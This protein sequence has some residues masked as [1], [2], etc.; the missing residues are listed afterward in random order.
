MNKKL[1]MIPN[2]LS[3]KSQFVKCFCCYYGCGAVA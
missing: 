2:A 3:N 1:F